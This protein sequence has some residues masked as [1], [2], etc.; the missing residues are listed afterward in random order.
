MK[1]YPLLSATI[2][3]RCDIPILLLL[4]LL[5][6]PFS[7][8]TMAQTSREILYI[9]TYSQNQSKGIYVLEFDRSTFS[10][11]VLQ[12]VHDKKNPTFLALHPSGKFLYAAYREGKN[13]EDP[14]GTVAAYAI[15]EGTGRLSLL[16]WVSSAG[17]SPCHISVDPSGSVVFV[18]HYQGGNLSSFKVLDS[19]QVSEAVSF[20]QHEGSSIH[21]NQTRPHMHSMIPSLDGNWVYA[22]DLGIDQLLKYQV[23]TEKGSLEN[24]P[25]VFP[26]KAGSG[27]RHF[28]LH[29]VLPYAYSVEELS[30]TVGIYAVDSKNGD[31]S[32]LSRV[33][34]LSPA[35]HSDYNAAADIHLSVDGN[36]LYASN[37]GQDNLAVY[38]VDQNTGLL[39]LQ[40]HVPTGGKHPRNF[41]VDEKG[42]LLF[43][44]NMESDN[45]VIFT[46]PKDR[47]IPEP[48]GKSISIP[49]AVFVEQLF[50]D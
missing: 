19:G 20:V 39:G 17:A 28:V 14:N 29:P 24:D 37:R 33:D 16:N 15:E 49:R 3:S 34:M 46:I 45:V 47:G 4:I 40:G 26:V 48:T 35:L 23:N 32:L 41:K 43:V 31:L 9:G 30:N 5:A 2:G 10:A 22:S 21:P 38:R 11:R 27:P 7:K 36:W 6:A 1:T 42:A 25:E 8:K 18:S 12:T 13:A 50:M 44:A